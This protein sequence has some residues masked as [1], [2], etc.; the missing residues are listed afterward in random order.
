MSGNNPH[1]DD[2]QTMAYWWAGSRESWEQ[3][4]WPQARL[5]STLPANSLARLREDLIEELHE[6]QQGAARAFSGPEFVRGWNAAM[7]A[8]ISR[9]YTRL[10]D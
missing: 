6:L 8:A 7:D 3:A 2:P 4:R 9:V 1:R 5:V 10:R